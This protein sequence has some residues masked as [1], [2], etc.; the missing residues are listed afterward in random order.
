MKIVFFGR[1]K[2][3][4]LLTI[5]QDRK[6][7]SLGQKMPAEAGFKSDRELFV[8]KVNIT[9]QSLEGK[10]GATEWLRA[11]GR[12]MAVRPK[13]NQRKND[14]LAF[15]AATITRW[16]ATYFKEI[17]DEVADEELNTLDRRE[18][19]N[20]YSNRSLIIGISC[21]GFE[22]C[23]PLIYDSVRKEFTFQPVKLVIRGTDRQITVSLYEV[24]ENLNICSVLYGS[25]AVVLMILLY[26][27]GAFANSLLSTGF[28]QRK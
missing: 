16:K 6:I 24:D 18:D 13:A 12:S 9:C 11:V 26:T 3:A 7:K 19:A 2:L 25:T 17:S 21:G 15:D 1:C 23:Q 20:R 8:E 14:S 10:G 4:E 22:Q 5:D 28:F 27:R